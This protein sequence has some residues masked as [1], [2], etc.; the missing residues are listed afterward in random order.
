MAGNPEWTERYVHPLVHEISEFYRAFCHMGEDGLWHFKWDPC[1]RQDW[2]EIATSHYTDENWIQIYETSGEA[3][4]FFYMTTHGMILQS[5]I[6]NYVNDHWGE[7][8]IASC[9]VFNGEV[10]FGN[11]VTR[12]GVNV[13]GA[14]REEDIRVE[15]VA[16]RDCDF[17]LSG[18]VIQMKR[19]R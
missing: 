5:L 8:E 15:L 19:G 6:R 9:P 4:K 11:I 1:I 12:L 10:S 7:L 13:S 16:Q 2:A 14:A 17:R 18:N 3:E